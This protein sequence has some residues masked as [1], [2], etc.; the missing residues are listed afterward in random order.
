M[1]D[2]F[3][4]IDSRQNADGT[5]ELDEWLASFEDYGKE[6]VRSG[7]LSQCKAKRRE[8]QQGIRDARLEMDLSSMHGS[9]RY[10]VC[11]LLMYAAQFEMDRAKGSKVVPG[12][13]SKSN[14]AA[15]SRAGGGGL[16]IQQD[17][18]GLSYAYHPVFST[19]DLAP[20]HLL[21]YL[22]DFGG[23]SSSQP[24]SSAK[25][26][27]GKQADPAAVTDKER[28]S[29]RAALFLSR[30]DFIMQMN[31]VLGITDTDGSLEDFVRSDLDIK[32]NERVEMQEFLDCLLPNSTDV[33][34]LL[35]TRS[36][37]REA[38]EQMVQAAKTWS[39]ADAEAFS[40]NA[41][42]GN[43]TL[44][45]ATQVSGVAAHLMQHLKL[46]ANHSENVMM[47]VNAWKDFGVV[48]LSFASLA[49]KLCGLKVTSASPRSK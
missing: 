28:A 1:S 34:E 14:V 13:G 6:R 25:H 42:A 31:A 44:T 30:D 36:E 49:T 43:G 23:L 9:V 35:Q 8:L 5:L 22:A 29:I 12:G 16:V 19:K 37:T 48:K 47:V 46:A 20:V 40:A 18:E 38:W 33:Q 10:E 15:G 27:Q 41:P 2:I 7:R 4:M 45:T 3:E 11:F 24:D 21:K 39:Q 32:H 26:G 17:K